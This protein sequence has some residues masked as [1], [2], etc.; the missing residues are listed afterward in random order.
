[1]LEGEARGRGRGKAIALAA[2]LSAWAGA[3][4]WAGAAAQP[5]AG[6]TAAGV[7]ALDPVV[8]TAT[9]TEER[10]FALPASIDAVEA[11]AIRDGKLRANLSESL[12]AIPGVV[13]NNR[14]NYA[15]DLQISSRGFGARAT[16][17]VRGVRLMQDGIP[18]TMP[19][20]QGQSGLFDLDAAA[21]IEV[22]R[23]PFAAL[24]GN[25]S[26]GV[27]QLFTQ[28]PPARP[29]LEA[30]GATGSYGT[31]RAAG[32]VGGTYE[33]IAASGGYSQFRTEGYRDW[34]SARR[35]ITNGRIQLDVGE[36]ATLTVLGFYVGQPNTQDPGGLT[37]QQVE[38]NPRQAGTDAVRFGAR[39]SINHGQGGAIYEVKVTPQDTVS[40]MGYVGDRQVTQFLAFQG[41]AITG[42]G[43]V[44]DLDR[45]F[46]G[47]W[48]TWRRETE[49]A[50]GPFTLAAAL[51]YDNMLE[52]R[53]GFVNNFGVAGALRRDEQDRV[54]DFA[55][56]VQAEWRFAPRWKLSAGVRHT[57]VAF[58]VTDYF[59]RPGNPDDSG[60]TSYSAWLPVG[61]ILY[62]LTPAVNLYASAGRGFETPTFAELAY[63]PDGLPGVNF[64]LRP[65]RSNLYEAGV[66]ALAGDR[67]RFNAVAYY[68]V[69]EQDI[70]AT[71][72][73]GVPPA[74]Q[75]RN[76]FTNAQRT[77]RGGFELSG[78]AWL[79]AGFSAV[80]AFTW[81][82]A[83]FSEYVTASGVD[84][85]GKRIPGVPQSLLYG[86]LKWQPA[87]T[88]P[89]L[90]IEGR[91]A[92]KVY[93]NDANTAYAPSYGI[94]NVVAGWTEVFGPFRIQAFLRADNVTDRR[95]IGSVIVNAANDRF[96]EP[97]PT[98]NV[99]GGVTVGVAF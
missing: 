92:A 19:D 51:N 69:T 53:R 94:L 33:G 61:G 35:D 52:R 5:A 85:S 50:G 93:A 37:L 58:K 59:V 56:Y 30:F 70:V 20:G 97:S 63:R 76:Y 27:I 88:G 68:S 48:L 90:G 36:R 60:T 24:Y 73:A 39:K 67:A 80:L 17:G 87:A 66:K 21:R 28:P 64:A 99:L 98:R 15:Q 89:S 41:A 81:L 74:P 13:A 3:F 26:G 91:Y 83:K 40:L 75:G 9:R 4:A 32:R 79:G 86:A 78:D 29:A 31:W 84:F 8:V 10:A 55:Q 77:T 12:G 7:V 62:E 34:S 2:R 72:Y 22:L 57:D 16:F 82:D 25:S 42:S 49:L 18:L 43:G 71:P 45:S 44:V 54:D 11:P 1:M 14:Q 96:F 47:V 65:A 46:G 95:Y 6:E 23:G 38:Q